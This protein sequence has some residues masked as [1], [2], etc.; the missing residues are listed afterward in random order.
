MTHSNLPDQ[1]K[2]KDQENQTSSSNHS[3]KNSNKKKK[4]TVSGI[5]FRIVKWFLTI[6]L[7]FLLLGAVI[8]GLGYLYFERDLPDVRELKNVKLQAPLQILSKEG[9]LIAV[10]G[11]KRRE[12]LKYEEIPQV[13]INAVIATED[14]RF[15]DHY[16]IDPVGI[17]R[18]LVV[19]IEN[20][21]KFS[22]GGSTI[23]Q[24][25]AKNY[26]LNSDKKFERK[27]K[28]AI[29]ALRMEKELSKDEIMTIYLNMIYFGSRSYG[30][31]A[32]AHTFFGKS[33]NELTLSEAALLAG[34]PNAPSA[35][36]PIYHPD[37]ALARRNWVLHRM[38]DQSMITKE[39]YQV[40]IQTPIDASYHHPTIDFSAPYVA[41]MARQFMFNRY[42]EAAYDDGYKVY[43]TITKTAQLAAEQA[44]VKQ[45]VDY[46]RS[47][48]YRGAEQIIWN[49]TD[50]LPSKAEMKKSLEKE[51]CFQHLCPG[52]VVQSTKTEASVM[53]KSGEQIT[54]TLKQIDWAKIKGAPVKNVSDLL[55]PGQLIRVQ[56]MTLENDQKQ[57]KLAQL[58]L[59]EGAFIALNDET[60]AVDALVGGFDFNRSKFNRVTQAIRQIG[61]TIKP[62]IYAATLENGLTLGSIINDTP[63]TRSAGTEIWR[64]KNDPDRY[65]GPMRLRTGMMLSKNVIMVRAMRSIGVETAAD[66]LLNFGFPKENISYNES[67]ALGAASFT[68]LQVARAY[69]AIA[70]G[71]YLITPYLIDKVEQEDEIVYQPQVQIACLECINVP[72]NRNLDQY[73]FRNSEEVHDLDE[74][75]TP[76]ENQLQDSEDLLLAEH[77]ID[78]NKDLYAPKVINS[79]V[80]FLIKDAMHSVIYGEKGRSGTAWRSRAL[81]RQDSGGKTGTTNGSKDVWFAGYLGNRVA[82]VWMGFD[83][84]R[85]ALN[86]ASGG[87]T[88]NPIWNDYMEAVKDSIPEQNMRKPKNVIKVNIDQ[89]TGLRSTD[90][91]N[92]V[93][94]YYIEGTEPQNYQKSNVSKT[95]VNDAGENE[96]IF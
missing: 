48:G 30:I 54:L 38:L 50:A 45:L 89:T 20:K 25:V 84:H 77:D 73:E 62:F 37:K 72:V 10:F 18:A 82:V 68:P 65:E 4:R 79:D 7:T 32:A 35:Y 19:A 61:S 64:P 23:T 31:S 57:W 12:P 55:K 69:S 85:Y 67:L 95:I 94:E 8:G 63:I 80:A 47:K 16:G 43:T 46:D 70:N 71:G 74:D 22:Q 76:D 59:V 3:N 51:M 66:Y 88:A 28:E 87:K 27:A 41:E 78:D 17:M 29:L 11:E 86:K 13:V 81:K 58:P 1:M 53:L 6:L 26:F 49:E 36:N 2:N 42:G 91:S 60:G 83:D 56:E 15:Y 34:L 40:A 52:L 21:G 39:E 96:S 75:E 93:S 33:A 92:M 44:L 24:Q 9:E 90:K 14:S 5:F